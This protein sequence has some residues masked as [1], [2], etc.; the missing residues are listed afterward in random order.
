M[1]AFWPR[2]SLRPFALVLLIA[3]YG[4]AVT[5][6]QVE[7][8]IGRGVGLLVLTAAW[9][10]LPR[11]PERGWRAAGAAGVA[12]LVACVAALPAAARYEKS[13][14]LVDYESWN[15]FAA[16]AT[17]AFDWSHT[18]G[19]IDWPRKGTTLMNVR[20]DERHYWRVETLDTLR[21]HPL[22]PCRGR[23]GQRDRCCRRR[24]T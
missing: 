17:T 6:H 23:A 19:P 24:T 15:P 8:E 5:E 20:S 13:E 21:R 14:P 10:W 1:L 22:G 4:V 12:V 11:M 2:Q 3:L 16:R 9:L 18:Y 7:R